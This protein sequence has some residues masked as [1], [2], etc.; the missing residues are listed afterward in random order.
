VPWSAGEAG[1]RHSR[2]PFLSG[3]SG[4]WSSECSRTSEC[5]RW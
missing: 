4:D 2:S 3:R 5:Y 1:V